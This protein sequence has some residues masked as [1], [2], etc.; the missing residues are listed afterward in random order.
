MPSILSTVLDG[1]KSCSQA[2]ATTCGAI[3]SGS[4][5]QNTKALRARISVSATITATAEP[6][7]TATIVPPSAVSRLCRVAVQ[8]VGLAKT[9]VSV[10]VEKPPVGRDRLRAAGARA[11]AATG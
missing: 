6:I 5:K 9:R 8:V 1:P 10:A 3:I 2:S 11:A 4:T 7:T